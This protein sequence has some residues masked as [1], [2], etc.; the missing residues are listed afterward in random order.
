MHSAL[1][2][3]E[4]I[5][6]PSSA[7]AVLSIYFPQCLKHNAK[8]INGTYRIVCLWNNIGAK[9]FSAVPGTISSPAAARIQTRAGL[10]AA[11]VVVWIF[12]LCRSAFSSQIEEHVCFCQALQFPILPLHTNKHDLALLSGLPGQNVN[13]ALNP[14][15]EA[16]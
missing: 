1:V 10:F 16:L 9:A 5:L 7:A 14:K 11:D 12:H 2:L 13:C 6:P 15:K 8:F 3:S 4:N